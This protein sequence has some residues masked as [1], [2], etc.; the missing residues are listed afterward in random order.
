MQ[1]QVIPIAKKYKQHI[2]AA[3]EKV[4]Q[5]R[6][7]KNGYPIEIDFNELPMLVD[8][9]SAVPGPRT[10]FFVCELEDGTRMLHRVR[11]GFPLNY[12]REAVCELINRLEKLRRF[13]PKR[14]TPGSEI[15][16]NFRKTR[17]LFG[18]G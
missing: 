7:D 10:P 12:G 1:I 6:T 15:S 16:R 13:R 11:G 17:P 2:A 9:R 8:M 18:P 14:R 3:L 5:G 4:G